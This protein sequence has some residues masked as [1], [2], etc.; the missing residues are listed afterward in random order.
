MISFRTWRRA[1]AARR[2]FPDAWE[3]ILLDSFAIWSRLSATDRDELKRH[4]L[5]F[6][7]E[8]HF[9]GC[10][11]LKITDEV[12][13]LIAAQA[14]LLLLHRETGYYPGVKTILVYPSA[15][16]ATS[17]RTG[18][19]GVITEETGPRLG[20][21]WHALSSPLSG[22][23]VILAWD[24]V[25][26]GAADARDGHNVVLHEFAHALDGESGGMDGAPA[27]D[28]RS[29]YLAW[30]RVLGRE[31]QNLTRAVVERAPHALNAYGATNPAEFFAVATEM[32][33]EQPARLKAMHPDLY[34][35]LREFYKQDPAASAQAEP[36]A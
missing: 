21:A 18:P 10:A 31:Y 15:F 33:F 27:L 16:I 34:S 13:V 8:K 3:S 9:E 29:S 17:K 25:V 7:A 5:I 1:R 20:E 30:A 23:P 28:R 6:L 11:G 32:F 19:G 26:R 24:S 14:C 22:G 35:Q 4:I 2:P 12:R 36:R